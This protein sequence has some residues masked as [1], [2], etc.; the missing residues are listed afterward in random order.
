MWIMF[1]IILNITEMNNHLFF[2]ETLPF[3]CI[4]PQKY[5]VEYYLMVYV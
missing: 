3:D 5:L 2:A 4:Q 1:D